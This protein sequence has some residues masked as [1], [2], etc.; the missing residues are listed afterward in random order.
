M[1]AAETDQML[2]REKKLAASLRDE[3]DSVKQQMSVEKDKLSSALKS[4]A[5][6][7][8]QLTGILLK[9]MLAALST[10]PVEIRASDT[11]NSTHM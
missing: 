3:L 11:Q 6:S 8:S 7:A 1:H 5:A 9:V 2:T 10:I 4:N